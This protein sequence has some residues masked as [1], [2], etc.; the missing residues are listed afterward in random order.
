[1][2]VVFIHHCL[3]P[4]SIIEHGLIYGTLKEEPPL[5]TYPDSTFLQTPVTLHFTARKIMESPNE[6]NFAQWT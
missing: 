6:A 1:M 3:C 5:G 2:T 4:L